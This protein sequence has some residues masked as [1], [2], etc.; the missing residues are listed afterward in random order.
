M[1]ELYAE[2]WEYRRARDAFLEYTR[3]RP[4]DPNG[5]RKLA[6]VYE[7]LGNEVEANFGLAIADVLGQNSN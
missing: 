2:R 6:E 3:L 7:K 4:K 1:G 5:H